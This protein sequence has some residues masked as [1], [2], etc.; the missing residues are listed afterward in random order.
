MSGKG[1]CD[2]LLKG[3]A[4]RAVKGNVNAACAFWFYQSK[5]PKQ[6][7]KFKTVKK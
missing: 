7:E 5:V 2:K 4:E 6:A 1:M 3:V